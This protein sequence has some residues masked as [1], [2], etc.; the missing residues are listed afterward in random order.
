MK[1]FGA[2]KPEL[3]ELLNWLHGKVGLI[4][5]NE[6]IF[7]LKPK[8]EANKVP[9]AARAGTVAPL[10]VIIPPGPTNMDPSQISFFHAL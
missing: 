5:T 10:D 7:E 8:V 3:K 1:K 2:P 4:F 6:P 9:A